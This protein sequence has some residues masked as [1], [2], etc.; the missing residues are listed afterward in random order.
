MRTTWN[1]NPATVS[2]SS[3][4]AMPAAHPQP[5]DTPPRMMATSV[6]NSAD[7]GNPD[8]RKD[9]AT[10]ARPSGGTRSSDPRRRPMRREPAASV[11]RPTD[12]NSDAFTSPCASRWS[13]SAPS[14]T[15]P[16][17]PSAS[18]AIPACSTD[19]Y[20][21][22]RFTSPCA[23]TNGSATVSDSN[24]TAISSPDEKPGP[25]AP[26]ATAWKRARA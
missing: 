11:S 3:S 14:A 5:V 6:T 1:R 7:G 9:P 12:T 15:V 20:A 19:E 26:A 24:P 17:K 8:N 25:S 22:S 10:N 23:T 2:A 4:A 18:A 13:A 16:P 21:S